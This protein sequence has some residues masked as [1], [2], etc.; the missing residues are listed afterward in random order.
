[1]NAPRIDGIY[2]LNA[3]E[4][5][6]S[7]YS[8]ASFNYPSLIAMSISESYAADTK[9]VDIGEF[10]IG[11]G[12]KSF[13]VGAF[14]KMED[15][16]IKSFLKQKNLHDF[17]ELRLLFILHAHEQSG[18]ISNSD[19]HLFS[20]SSKLGTIRVDISEKSEA[21]HRMTVQEF[22]ESAIKTGE[23]FDMVIMDPPYNAKYDKIYQTSVL[24]K[25]DDSGQFLDWL[26]SKVL[27]LLDDEGIIISK[28]WR[29]IN[30]QESRFVAGMVTFYGGFRRATL[31]EAWQYRPVEPFQFSSVDYETDWKMKVPRLRWIKG[32]QSEWTP[33][34]LSSVKA[35]IPA[36]HSRKG[37]IISDNRDA[38]IVG[39]DLNQVVFLDFAK[40]EFTTKFDIIFVEECKKLGGN[41][42][43][44]NAFK[45][46][47]EAN[48]LPG[49]LAIIKSYF[50]P[51]LDKLESQMILLKD[52]MVVIY[53]DYAKMNL[54][55]CY[56][57]RDNRH[58]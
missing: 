7:D 52:R 24:N 32:I 58:E 3:Q 35:L 20:G 1:M 38:N 36:T 4:F 29:S 50:D 46:K 27:L 25:I 51:A 18:L 5:K 34:E 39:F 53:D 22:I 42:I 17:P 56:Q 49:G 2:F 40:D 48:L 41:V 21:T 28:N 30:P 14:T 26:V 47:I 16:F 6:E 55:H 45:K 23:R 11:T 12:M 57:K 15:Q 10:L 19:V 9:S 54:L 37:I 43:S 13:Y 44:T 33:Y 31:L 8:I